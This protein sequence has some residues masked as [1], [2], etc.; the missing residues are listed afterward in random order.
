MKPALTS[1]LLLSGVPGNWKNLNST[2]SDIHQIL[3]QRLVPER[4]GNSE[5]LLLSLLVLGSDQK[6]VSVPGKARLASEVLKPGIPEVSKYAFCSGLFH[7]VA[8][9]G[10]Q[11]LCVL[12]CMTG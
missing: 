6:R 1:F 11:P 12:R 7:R 2:A 8:V 10:F 5:R 4:V 9:I 3:L